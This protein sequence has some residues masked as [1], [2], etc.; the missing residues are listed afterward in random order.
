MSKPKYLKDADGFCYA[1][2]PELAA[3][4]ELSPYDGKVTDTGHAH[5]H[6][7]KNGTVV[8]AQGDTTDS[9]VK[10]VAVDG[11]PVAQS[12]QPGVTQDDGGLSVPVIVTED[13]VAGKPRA[14]KTVE[15]VAK[16]ANA[17]DP[18]PTDGGKTK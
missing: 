7:R 5:G 4:S 18:K 6:V 2:T 16:G 10:G 11:T 12:A 3:L 14:D 13:T 17:T 9:R 1:Y 15:G 8:G